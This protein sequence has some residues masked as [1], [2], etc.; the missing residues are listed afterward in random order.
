MIH[1]FPSDFICSQGW[2]SGKRICISLLWARLIL[3]CHSF[4]GFYITFFKGYIWE[5]QWP[6][7]GKGDAVA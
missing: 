5:V 1:Q 6:G 7:K 4:F 3:K 2:P